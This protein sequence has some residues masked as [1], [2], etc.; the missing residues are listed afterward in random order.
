[1]S[2]S[3]ERERE[4]MRG[5][6]AWMLALLAALTVLLL[7]IGWH[8]KGEAGYLPFVMGILFALFTLA[9]LAAKARPSEDDE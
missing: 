9:S 1:M 8:D 3:I 4:V 5:L 7:V 2:A 6:P